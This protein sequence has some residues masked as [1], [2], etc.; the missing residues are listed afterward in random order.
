MQPLLLFHFVLFYSVL[1]CSVLFCSVLFCSVLFCSVLFYSILFYSILFHSIPFYS[2]YSSRHLFLFLSYAD[3]SIMIKWIA[4][5]AFNLE[6][7]AFHLQYRQG[8]RGSWEPQGNMTQRV[9]VTYCVQSVVNRDSW[10]LWHL[11]FNH[12]WWWWL[13]G[14]KGWR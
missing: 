7:S 10:C 5:P 9:T 11:I 8:L 3:T 4:P 12:M 2:L 1:F 6:I 14:G 13:G